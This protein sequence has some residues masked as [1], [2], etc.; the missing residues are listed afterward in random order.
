MAWAM[1]PW[2]SCR[3]SRQSKE[4][5]SVNWA[6]SAA[7]PPAKRPLRETGG[8]LRAHD[9]FFSVKGPERKGNFPEQFPS[10][11]DGHRCRKPDSGLATPRIKN[12]AKM[13]CGFSFDI[14]Q[15]TFDIS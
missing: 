1:E 15:A 3:Q 9:P 8:G 13:R 12:N 7:G 4:M 11:T 10:T 2:M 5:D 6:T 14:R